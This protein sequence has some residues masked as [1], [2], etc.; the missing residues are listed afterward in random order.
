MSGA[1]ERWSDIERDTRNQI[2]T[3]FS[4]LADREK[5]EFARALC[6][7]PPFVSCALCVHIQSIWLDDMLAF[8]LHWAPEFA[9]F[10][11]RPALLCVINAVHLRQ[12]QWLTRSFRYCM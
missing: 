1:R 4:L 6:T 11:F 10:L 2:E 7:W 8:Q 3:F 5:I 9:C 12:F